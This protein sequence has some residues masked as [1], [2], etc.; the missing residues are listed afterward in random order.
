[1]EAAGRFVRLLRKPKIAAK[2]KGDMDPIPEDWGLDDAAKAAEP[3]QEDE[4]KE[5]EAWRASTAA[6]D[7]EPPAEVSKDEAEQEQQEE[8]YQ[9]EAEEEDAADDP[10]DDLADAAAD[11]N[12]EDE[13]HDDETSQGMHGNEYDQM[14]KQMKGLQKFVEAEHAKKGEAE[15]DDAGDKGYHNEWY[16]NKYRNKGKGTQNWSW[17]SKGN[18]GKGWK[19]GK[20]WQK[21]S[22]KGKGKWNWGKGG[23]WQSNWEDWGQGRGDMLVPDSK[24]KGYYLPNGQG[25]LDND[26]VYHPHLGHIDFCGVPECA[27]CSCAYNV[28]SRHE[29]I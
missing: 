29:I 13:E 5:E 11:A 4:D 25:F 7:G 3:V 1:M 20:G 6:M 28:N 16:Y 21:R 19:N 2:P 24:G 9:E 17:N 22:P 26:G 27:S 15:K 14:D 10:A 18:Y 12:D 23:K 8:E